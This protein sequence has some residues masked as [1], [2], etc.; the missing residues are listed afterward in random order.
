VGNDALTR[1]SLS[2]LNEPKSAMQTVNNLSASIATATTTLQQRVK[3]TILRHGLSSLPL[4]ILSLIRVWLHLLDGNG[5]FGFTTSGPP[6]YEPR[7]VPNK[8][9]PLVCRR[10]RE[11]ELS[12][13]ELWTT[14][15][16]DMPIERVKL[17]I[18]RS[19]GLPLRV[20]VHLFP[21]LNMT[22][23]QGDFCQC[24]LWELLANH[25]QRCE[26]VYRPMGICLAQ[27]YA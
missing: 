6:Q 14:V 7:M 1:A 18:A 22:G 8:S 26:D 11:V 19:G 9:F 2:K 12:T 20:Q 25:A 4:E 23:E 13:P 16:K 3:P 24:D 21:H 10:F 27:R 5:A 15:F 17:H